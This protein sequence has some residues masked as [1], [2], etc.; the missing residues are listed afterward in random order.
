MSVIYLRHFLHGEKVACGELEAKAD[1]G[2]GW[3]DFDPY[4]NVASKPDAPPPETPKTK[5]SKK[6]EVG[7]SDNTL[8]NALGLSGTAP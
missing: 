3:V 8:L 2:N 5:G 1:R 7:M 4:E 6:S